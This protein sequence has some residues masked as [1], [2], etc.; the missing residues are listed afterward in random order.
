MKYLY[1]LSLSCGY[2]IAIFHLVDTD[3]QKQVVELKSKIAKHCD[4]CRERTASIKREGICFQCSSYLSLCI[5]KMKSTR[6][7]DHSYVL[8]GD[9]QVFWI[10]QRRQE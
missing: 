10:S 6:L 5:P 2:Y 9:R 1:Y 8:S 3:E 4:M 7:F